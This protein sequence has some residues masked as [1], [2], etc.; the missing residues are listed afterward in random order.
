M[1]EEI[2]RRTDTRWF[3]PLNTLTQPLS[4]GQLQHIFLHFCFVMTMQFI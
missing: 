3:V 2:L 1:D 4:A